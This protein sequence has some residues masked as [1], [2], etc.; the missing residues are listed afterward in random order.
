MIAKNIVAKT[1]KPYLRQI[2]SKTLSIDESEFSKYVAT[3][4][5]KIPPRLQLSAWLQFLF[6]ERIIFGRYIRV[7]AFY[8]EKYFIVNEPQTHL[9]NTCLLT[10]VWVTDLCSVFFNRLL[11]VNKG[12]IQD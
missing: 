6:C 7:T 12:C 4:E 1:P 10:K 11:I 9:I 3:V 8:Q 2:Q 5:D